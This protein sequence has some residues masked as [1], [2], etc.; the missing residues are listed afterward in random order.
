MKVTLEKAHTH[1]GV[2]YQT[3]DVLDVPDHLVPWLES[4]GAVKPVGGDP[5]PAKS[6]PK[7]DK[8]EKA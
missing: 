2:D 6:R 1:A 5:A 8:K 7:P 3:G 4:V